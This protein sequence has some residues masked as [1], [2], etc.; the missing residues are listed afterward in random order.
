MGRL[1]SSI[2]LITGTPIKDTVDQLINL[3]AIP[4]NRLTNRTEGLKQQRSAITDLTVLSIGLQIS[5]KSFG[6]TA[7]FNRTKASSTNADSVSVTRSGTPELGGYQVRTLQTAGTQAFKSQTFSSSTK[8]FGTSGTLTIR[9]GG[10]VDRST[11]LSDLNGGRGVEAGS[12]RITD[13]S[14][15]SAVIDLSTA[16][17]ID[18]VI[19]AINES[20]DINVTATSDGDAIRLVDKTG[21]T[22]SN[23]I[24]E[25]IGGGETAADL[26]LR[27]INTNSDSATGVDILRLS[28]GTKLSSLLDGRGLDFG[29]GDDL[30]FTFRDGSTLDLEIGDFSRVA[31]QST[32]TTSSQVESAALTFKAVEEGA[33]ADGTKIRFVDDPS[34]VAG[35]ET[36]QKIDTPSGTEL[37]FS[38]SAGETTAANIAAALERDSSM[39]DEFS[40]EA[41]GDGSGLVSVSDTAT[42]SGGSAIEAVEDPD[43][44]D[45][46]RVLNDANPGRLRAELA[47]G[48]D[49]I[50]LI[51]LTEGAGEFTVADKGSSQVA[52]NLGLTGAASD[53]GVIAGGRLLSGLS[54]VSLSALGGGNGL[55]SLGTLDIGG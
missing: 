46:L 49:S 13:R 3:S 42:L 27:G 5:A 32:G 6:T 54:S 45:L 33:A 4:R 28:S 14:G 26:G 21:K 35:S 22:I 47:P 48:G 43:I 36:V 12:I 40:V 25:D 10:Y 38:I 8:A 31:S 55:G 44:G 39:S 17:T 30:A 11:N 16:A 52:A 2:G 19:D 20:A 29:D 34:I 37:V 9:G 7:S 51:D 53:E 41:D 15:E 1:S 18:D 50:R 23:L 24:V